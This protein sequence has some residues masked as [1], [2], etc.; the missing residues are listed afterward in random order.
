MMLMYP[1]LYLAVGVHDDIFN[2]DNLQ[3]LGRELD[4]LYKCNSDDEVFPKPDIL[5]ELTR[6]AQLTDKNWRNFMQ[7]KDGKEPGDVSIVSPDVFACWPE[8]IGVSA[9]ALTYIYPRWGAEAKTMIYLS[10]LSK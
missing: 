5:A 4:M 6:A 9:D 8:S 7:R 1:R 10:I 2:E 3:T